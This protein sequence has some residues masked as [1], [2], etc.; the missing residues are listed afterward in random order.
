MA[1][2][3][4]GI[5]RSNRR[6]VLVAFSV[7]FGI[8]TS[9]S[10]LETARDALFLASVPATRLPWV[11][12]A[13]AGLALG[14]VWLNDRALARLPPRRLL[15]GTLL[16]AAA[17]TSGFWFVGD[18]AGTGALY[19]FYI[20]TGLLATVVVAQFWILLSDRF[21]V[22][23]AKRAYAVIAA[24]GLLGATVGS[25]GAG[26]LL[27][28]T[29]PRVLL[30]V[31][32][33]VLVLTAFVPL[34]LTIPEP[35]RGR[36]T[37]SAVGLRASL[38]EILE[39]P[40]LRRLLALVVITTITVTAVD[41]T[42][43]TVVAREVAPEDLGSFFAAFYAAL[44]ALG[45]VVQIFFASLIIG[46]LGVNRTL[47]ILPVL[48]LASAIGFAV[49]VAVIPVLLLKAF[50]GTLRHSVNKTGAE[51]LFLPVPAGLRARSKVFIDGV[52]ARS[53]QALAALAMLG[54]TALAA[55]PSH[56]AAAVAVAAVA[57]LLLVWGLKRHY[58]ELFRQQLRSGRMETRLHAPELDLHS[59]ETL[60]SALNSEDE[61]MV[62][63]A[64]DL[65]EVSGRAKL[66][67][68]L[69]LYHP[70]TPVVLRALEILMTDGRTDF[71]PIARRL[72]SSADPEIRE[73][74]LRAC[75]AIEPDEGV[76]RTATLDPSALVRS[77]A[78]VGL[79]AAHLCDED[80][81][82][83]AIHQIIGQGTSEE[84]LALA[85]AI[86][87]PQTAELR[88]ALRQLA[89]VEEP[90]VQAEVARAIAAAPDPEL[91]PL[92][93]P[94]LAARRSRGEARAA[95]VAHGD[96][97][98]QALVA[99][100]EDDA[101]PSQIRLHIPRTLS[102]FGTAAAAAALLAY[103]RHAPDGRTSYKCLRGLG[104]MVADDDSL[105]IAREQ[106]RA[107]ALVT[108]KRALTLL[109][110]RMNLERGAAEASTR[111]TPGAEL[112][113]ELLSE[114]ESNNIERV[115]RLFGLLNPG[116]DFERIYHGLFSGDD[117]SRASS[118]ELIEHLIDEPVRSAV[119]ALADDGA[120]SVRL[121][122][123]NEF[124]RPLMASYEEQLAVMLRDQS[125]AVRLL[126]AHHVGEL[127]LD[128]LRRDLE[129]MKAEKT[130]VLADVITRALDILGLPAE[131]SPHAS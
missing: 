18:R 33:A 102:R 40:Y 127:G 72:L 128:H 46:S 98:F 67:P 116:E 66:V 123:A 78:I 34:A 48:L 89:V 17:V 129:A 117:K 110:W 58:L 73:A 19:A 59:L 1:R 115:F 49:T 122:E 36:A 7:L 52:G 101:T 35:T 20:W 54:F 6:D 97:G 56:M 43:K 47:L 70:S 94:M 68:A 23:S 61:R 82:R 113:V 5:A 104:R 106:V 105:I 131:P 109:A 39:H 27:T 51:V 83:A 99:A 44:N 76:L 10:M 75:S 100:L 53:G 25:A 28:F 41:L 22:S 93:L 38:R 74:M 71:V 11:Y 45:L 125:E 32:P 87:V 120:D 107:V 42:F 112:L 14:V 55:R 108:V 121:L 13:I 60:L 57:W 79:A 15:V 81:L 80:E 31:A 9:H 84:R 92:L 21:D 114:K 16:V 85:R 86:A 96:A 119:L 63:N 8:L 24:G 12:L 91:I 111:R 29:G 103:M 64:L 126:A 130:G 95:L 77:T 65:L 88:W 30:L 4:L 37:R 3:W 50:D 26:A 2:A 90:A 118:R 62:C 124:Y 69:I